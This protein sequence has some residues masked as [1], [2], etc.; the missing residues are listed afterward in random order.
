VNYFDIGDNSF[1][2]SSE[3]DQEDECFFDEA[4][5]VQRSRKA[6][7]TEESKSLSLASKF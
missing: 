1:E 4:N 5:A 6:L 2:R 3:E 7:A